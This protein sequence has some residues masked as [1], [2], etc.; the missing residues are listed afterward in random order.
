MKTLWSACERGNALFNSQDSGDFTAYLQKPDKVWLEIDYRQGNYPALNVAELE[1]TEQE[2]A[3]HINTRLGG[4]YA[5]KCNI[6]GVKLDESNQVE[7][8]DYGPDG[9]ELSDGGVIEY[10]EED[11]GVIR[12]RDAHGNTEEIR[13]PKDDNYLEWYHLFL[14]S[15]SFYSGQRVHVDVD[16]EQWGRVVS[17]ATVQEIINGCAHLVLVDSIRA[18]IIVDCDDLTAIM[19]KGKHFVAE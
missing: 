15:K 3:N 8:L 10:P 18:A 1:I 2:L 17:D 5:A 11:S 14:D 13:E 9:V 19:E 4:W 7:E 6:E 12:R 16:D